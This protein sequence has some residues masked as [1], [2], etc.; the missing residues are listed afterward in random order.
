MPDLDERLT[1]ALERSAHAQP[2]GPE[3]FGDIVRRRDRRER[4]RRVQRGA[5]AVVVVVATLGGSLVIRDWVGSDAVPADHPTNGRILFVRSQSELFAGGG[6]SAS[7]FQIWSID[8]A[9]GDLAQLP[10]GDDGLMAAAW[11]PD[12]RRIAYLARNDDPGDVVRPYDLWVVNADGGDP[13]RWVEGVPMPLEPTLA[14]T[15]DG[16]EVAVLGSRTRNGLGILDD[17]GLP[18][19]DIQFAGPDGSH[20]VERDGSIVSFGLARDGSVAAVVADTTGDAPSPLGRLI[21]FVPDRG[22]TGRERT[23]AQGVTWT[24]AP[25]WSPTSDEVVFGR[26][27]EQRGST[28]LWIAGTK[29]EEER[30]LV[31]EDG[32]V[33]SVAWA[34]DG[35][36]ILYTRQTEQACQIVSITPDGGDRRVVADRGDL[37]GCPS[38]LSWQAIP[39]STSP[40]ATEAPASDVA[41][42]TDI[43]LDFR[44]CDVQR[45]GGIDFF[46]DDSHGGAWTGSP[47][48]ESGRCSNAYDAPHV[49]AV[50]LDGDGSADSFADLPVCTGCEPHD[51]TDLGGDGTKELVVLLQ[52]GSTPQ[53]GIFDVIPEGLPRSAGVYPLF[54]DPP[55][56]RRAGLPPGEP[57]TL[58]A[59]GDEGFSAAVRCEGYPDAP[60]LV[61]AWSSYSISDAEADPNATEAFHLTRL[62]LEEPGPEAASFVVVDTANTERP[63]GEPLPFETPSRTCGVDWTP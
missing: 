40:D 38:S 41:L 48:K 60:E 39:A 5:L 26:R 15:P 62:L 61:L 1:R 27:A 19:L 28:E 49:V 52:Y 16:T 43:G 56:A 4:V 14:W 11:S 55:G 30:R 7:Q 10:V 36:R 50:D 32:S 34:P 44:L 8:A 22:G 18:L 13:V 51:A 6:S 23:L 3:V 20:Y 46:G 58:W 54:V 29:G 33:D 35:S 12:G 57:I 59:G 2:A 9:G 17:F 24:I 21:G 25:A 37:H 31:D 53:Y 63:Y 45:L 42:G 47:L